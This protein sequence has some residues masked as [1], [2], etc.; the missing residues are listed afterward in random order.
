MCYNNFIRKHK[1]VQLSAGLAEALDGLFF[2]ANAVIY[3]SG[4]I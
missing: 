3:V 4:Y 1:G 2:P